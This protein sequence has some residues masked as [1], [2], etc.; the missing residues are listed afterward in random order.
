MKKIKVRCWKATAQCAD[1]SQQTVL[2][3]VPDFGDAAHLFICATCG[4]KFAVNPEEEFYTKRQFSELK[5]N[6]SCPECKAS[7]AEVLPYP[8]RFRC[9]STGQLDHYER[10]TRGI[11]SLDESIILEFWNP[12]S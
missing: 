12:L 6:L 1:G 4:A 9:E 3:T 7:L 10:P 8:E 2:F 11:P 5:Q